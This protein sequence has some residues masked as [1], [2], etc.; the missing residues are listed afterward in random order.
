MDTS[1]I[2]EKEYWTEVKAIAREVRR[3]AKERGE[4]ETDVLA[5]TVD[6]HQWVIYTWAAPYVLIHTRNADAAWDVTGCDPIGKSYGQLM[7]VLA[8]FALHED[9][10]EVLGNT[11]AA[12]GV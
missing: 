5:E 10:S 11:A 3:E 8:F 2:T 12:G 7:A 6:S 1:K 4:E 9:V